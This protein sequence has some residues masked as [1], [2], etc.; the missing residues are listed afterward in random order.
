MAD[1]YSNLYNTFGANALSPYASPQVY[2]R[3]MLPQPIGSTYNLTTASEIYNIPAGN[4][5]S[6]GICLNEQVMYLKSY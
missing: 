3:P 2:N 6:V 1:T 4:N 5:T